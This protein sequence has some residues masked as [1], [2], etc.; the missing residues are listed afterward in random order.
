MRNG[1]AG[2]GATT[3]EQLVVSGMKLTPCNSTMGQARDAILQA[4]AN[5]N[6]GANRCAIFAAFAHRLM[7]AGA[8][9]ATDNSTTT[10]V[11]SRAVPPE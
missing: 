6:G 11:T 3:A 8:S 9:S 5:I 1:V 10:I 2:V 4:D 7:G